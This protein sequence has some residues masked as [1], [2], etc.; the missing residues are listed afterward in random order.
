MQEFTRREFGPLPSPLGS[1]LE[2]LVHSN[3]FI[4]IAATSV[5]LTTMLL[6]ELRVEPLPLFIVFAAALFVYSLNRLT[7]IEEDRANLPGRADFTERFGRLLL[8]FGVLLYLVAVV[9][10]FVLGLPGA[11]FLVLPAVAAVLYST[12]RAK[13]LLLVKNAIVGISWGIIPLGVGVYYRIGF[14]VELLVLAGF[15]TVMLTVAAAVF[16]IKDLEGDDAAG[17]R[18]IPIAF[19]TRATRRGALVV[20]GLGAAVVVG[21]VSTGI[22]PRRFLVLLGF[23]GYIAAYIPF[24]TRDRGPLFYGLVIDGEHVFLAGLVIAMELL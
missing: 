7:D 9:G 17:I 24:A 15:F 8:A 23:L 10:A 16:D 19:G 3:L 21:L 5:A 12:F 20:T 18:T 13:Q 11:P 2:F 14:P 22:V 1:L 4:S 6:L